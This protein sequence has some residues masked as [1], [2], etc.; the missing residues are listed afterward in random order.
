MVTTARRWALLPTAQW[1]Q[2]KIGRWVVPGWGLKIA[3]I[4]LV[5]ASRSVMR[6]RTGCAPPRA[7][8]S[9]PLFCMTTKRRPM[10][11]KSTVELMSSLNKTMSRML[12]LIL[13]VWGTFGTKA[14]YLWAWNHRS[15]PAI[16]FP[17]QVCLK[18]LAKS[19]PVPAK[20]SQ[21]TTIQRPCSRIRMSD[22]APN[23]P[24]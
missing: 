10:R 21:A 9:N 17:T 24:T 13:D 18:Y 12:F 5:T 22:L 4:G 23:L 6:P 11:E 1:A 19:I 7:I 2:L 20:P 15:L 14:T 8:G 16:G 3:M